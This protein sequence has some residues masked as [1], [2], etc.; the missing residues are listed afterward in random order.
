MIQ[1]KWA[2]FA[3][4]I[5]M[6]I[7]T[8]GIAQLVTFLIEKYRITSELA[9]NA[10][11]QT[12]FQEVIN[13]TDDAAQRVFLKPSGEEIAKKRSEIGATIQENFINP[14]YGKKFP[15]RKDVCVPHPQTGKMVPLQGL[16][17]SEK[18]EVNNQHAFAHTRLNG[19][20]AIL[21][22]LYMVPPGQSIAYTENDP[23]KI[24]GN[25]HC[26]RV[27]IFSA[28][29]A[30]LYMKYQ[31]GCE[32]SEEDLL[33]IQLV[34]AG[35]DSGRESDGTDVWDEQ[36]AQNTVD[37]LRALGITDEALLK[38]CY[39]AVANKDSLPDSQKSIIAKCLQ[40]GD[41]ADF[42]RL[43]LWGPEAS[44]SNFETSRGYLDIYKELSHNENFVY[45]LDALRKEM[46]ELIYATSQ[47]SARA[48]L[49]Q[50]GNNVY[51]EILKQITPTRYPL[52]HKTLRDIG[53]IRISDPQEQQWRKEVEGMS[54]LFKQTGAIGHLSAAQYTH[55]LQKIQLPDSCQ[56]AANDP[57]L[58]QSVSL[59]QQLDRQ[60]GLQNDFESLLPN[61]ESKEEK[62]L[63]LAAFEKLSPGQKD[64]YR[65]DLLKRKMMPHL[66]KLDSDVFPATVAYFEHAKIPKKKVSIA[67]GKLIEMA[68]KT[69]ANFNKIADEGL[70]D[71]RQ[72]TTAA[73]LYKQASLNA[74][75]AN[76]PAQAAAIL[77]EAG[78]R[79]PLHDSQLQL[80]ELFPNSATPSN[81]VY[82]LLRGGAHLR[83]HRL[84][85]AETDVQGQRH[86]E[87]SFELPVAI[88]K[89]LQQ[90]IQ[91]LSDQGL[92]QVTTKPATYHQKRNGETL[93]DEPG[94][95]IGDDHHI[96]FPS[97]LELR[98]GADPTYKNQYTFARMTVPKD[99]PLQEIHQALT[100]VGLPM[101]LLPPRPEDFDAHIRA[102]ALNLLHPKGVYSNFPKLPSKQVY[103]QL[104]AHEKK[105]VDEYVKSA[106]FKVFGG[107][108]IEVICPKAA[109]DVKKEGAVGL[110]SFLFGGS[111]ERIS[112]TAGK[113]L[114]TGVLSAQER[115]QRGILS[116][117]YAPNLNY[118]TGSGNQVFAR[119]LT[120][121]Q[122]EANKSFQDFALNSPLLALIDVE[123]YERMPYFYH[124]DRGGLRNGEFATPL[125]YAPRQKILVDYKGHKALC[126]R[127][128][129]HK[130]VRKIN[131]T[132][133][134]AN[135]TVFNHSFVP[136][137]FRGLLVTSEY[138]KI[139][140]CDRLQQQGI[141]HINGKE[142]S[143]AVM[144]ANKI[145]QEH[146]A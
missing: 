67:T 21:A 122:L 57:Q 106:T 61:F 139:Q 125:W 128:P 56:V 39:E 107:R 42:P 123:A 2:A 68:Q 50:P 14:F 109:E 55:F 96:Q 80:K 64:H 134:F 60:L 54:L 13:R 16:T 51:D 59:C 72:L 133:S 58:L 6:G 100:L 92:A 124:E 113:I 11:K 142:L 70:R 140:L 135:E 22:E 28:L 24:H 143:Q 71:T 15:A 5:I 29:F 7:V 126:D 104:K 23:R 26:A 36:S 121:Q 31:K 63:L 44:E 19:A 81:E 65:R 37:R 132:Q 115:F 137:Y 98:I 74:L 99:T 32:L 52:M 34:A 41:C 138:D 127:P 85:V 114:Q 88:R 45:E 118:K 8:L 83:H 18:A 84:R 48:E 93:V 40:N 105:Q 69:V 47:R 120:K 77:K 9:R 46:D 108:S 76:N 49:S 91:L 103:D 4:T 1:E 17:M 112:N 101:A 73:M 79:I 62:D 89:D 75:S 136:E 27:S 20:W 25:D 97:G 82:T 94:M 43:L 87:L 141:Y 86:L 117:G 131:S 35:H 38:K 3:I 78:E 119:T 33:I 145:S 53:V 111:I 95:E 10:D 102:C 30:S 130:F 146:F 66:R 90:Y 129:L 144:V 110:G 12:R 116:A